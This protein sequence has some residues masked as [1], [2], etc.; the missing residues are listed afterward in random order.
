MLSAA[1]GN[2]IQ[3]A[4]VDAGTS[5]IQ[6]TVSVPRGTFTVIDPSLVGVAGN[7]T[8]S[9]TLTGTLAEINQTLAAGLTYRVATEG[10][11]YGY[12]GGE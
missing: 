8:S 4:D 5:D 10:E 2:A 12:C 7:G 3:V 11:C 6:V 1:N 9:V